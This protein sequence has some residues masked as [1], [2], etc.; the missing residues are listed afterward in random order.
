[1]TLETD[2][3][4]ESSHSI[5]DCYSSH[6]DEGGHHHSYVAII[7]PFFL[8]ATGAFLK[9]SFKSIPIPYTVLLLVLGGV[10]GLGLQKSD[11]WDNQF[12]TSMNFLADIP[13]HLLLHI[14]LPPLIFESAFSIEWYIFDKMKYTTA[15]L[16]GPGLVFSTGC[17]GLL[18][19]RVMIPF[20]SNTDFGVC[21]EGG[22][23]SGPG[24]SGWSPSA[25]FLLGAILSATDPV[26][27]VAL[28]KELGVPADLSTL[29]EGE[30][31]LNDGT[32]LVVYTVLVEFVEGT[33]EMT[34]VDVVWQFVKMSLGGLVF[35]VL[36][37]FLSVQWLGHIFNDAMVEITITLAVPYLTFYLAENLLHISGVL[38]L[39]ALG[40][41]YGMEGRSRISPEVQHFLG[42]FWELLAYFGNTL[43]FII[44]GLVI[45]KEFP[46]VDGHDIA[47][48]VIIYLFSHVIRAAVLGFVHLWCHLRGKRTNWN[49]D[50]VC[51]WGGLRGAVGLAL[52]LL[53]NTDNLICP[54]YK[55]VV[56]LQTAGLVLLTVIVNGSTMRPLLIRLGVDKVHSSRLLIFNQAVKALKES[57]EDQ[58]TLLK[59]DSLFDNADWDIVKSFYFQVPKLKVIEESLLEESLNQEYRWSVYNRGAT[60]GSTTNG[61]DQM[62]LA[63]R[64]SEESVKKRS[65]STSKRRTRS[66]SKRSKSL[67][68]ES[69]SI[70]HTNLFV[71]SH[72]VKEARRRLLM[73]CKKSYWRQFEMGLLSQEAA[74]FLMYTT[75]KAVDRGCVMAEWAYFE[76]TLTT[77]KHKAI[78]NGGH[79][80]SPALKFMDGIW[81]FFFIVALS[82][83]TAV[84]AFQ[85]GSNDLE[86]LITFVYPVHCWLTVVFTLEL[87]L[88]L[89]LL[90]DI[91][92]FLRDPFTMVDLGV[93]IIDIVLYYHPDSMGFAGYCLNLVRLL[94]GLRLLLVW[95]TAKQNKDKE[96]DDHGKLWTEDDHFFSKLK[97]KFIYHQVQFDYEVVCG[98]LSAREEA[99][100]VLSDVMDSDAPHFS[101]VREQALN[102]IRSAKHRLELMSQH[103]AEIS[104]SM[105]TYVAARTVLNQQRTMIDHLNHEGLLDT[106]EAIKMHGAVEHQMKK[107]MSKPPVVSLPNKDAI[108]RDL[109]WTS[110]LQQD[111]I[112]S[113]KPYFEDVV[114]E[115][116]EYVVKKG[117]TD[118]DVYVVARGNFTIY[119]GS[120]SRKREIGTLSMG[121]TFGEIS[122]ALGN[123]RNADV[124]SQGPGLV[125]KLNGETLH[126]LANLDPDLSDAIWDF[127]CRRLAEN[128]LYKES[129]VTMTR[130]MI[131]QTLMSFHPYY[132]S[133]ETVHTFVY[134]AILVLVNGGAEIIENV[135]APTSRLKLFAPDDEQ[136]EAHCHHEYV[137]GC[138]HC[139]IERHRE[140]QRQH[141][142]LFGPAI[143][144]VNTELT[145]FSVKFDKGAR[146]MAERTAFTFATTPKTRTTLFQ[147]KNSDNIGSHLIKKNVPVTDAR[148]NSLDN[149]KRKHSLR[150]TPMP[151]FPAASVT[152]PNTTR[153]KQSSYDE[154]QPEEG[155]EAKNNDQQHSNTLR[156]PKKDKTFKIKRNHSAS[157]MIPSSNKKTPNKNLNDQDNLL[158]NG[159]VINEPKRSNIVAPIAQ[160][161]LS[162]NVKVF[163]GL[164]NS[165]STQKLDES[166]YKKYRRNSSSLSER[167]LEIKVATSDANNSSLVHPNI[168]GNS[169]N[170]S[171]FSGSDYNI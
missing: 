160:H 151:K 119:D 33:F 25:G 150:N 156:L 139:E 19:N 27:V 45:G 17:I 22:F 11:E 15:F 42:E 32:A 142:K 118:N 62:L 73:V 134:D 74:K 77:F 99:L 52:A 30:S 59:Q 39:V 140:E 16:A 79:R 146:F 64:E 167:A 7:A 133:E 63:G 1:M 85:V 103:Y 168:R 127:V 96:R 126:S 165:S 125:Y 37:G 128:M 112:N 117:G 29:I 169:D 130:R 8:L 10:I 71:N 155:E 66:I 163:P 97:R 120:R 91:L 107:L 83:S 47:I 12:A 129:S 60:G 144:Q 124:I 164:N 28:L 49:Y 98:F 159:D 84:L 131:K 54:A 90:G 3:L 5:S 121:S 43:V 53:V 20:L 48:L 4:E 61:S 35:G 65:R 92:S 58:E 141:N 21:I 114:T 23:A 72:D 108:L 2:H 106:S 158:F 145:A 51:M 13:A 116:G 149:M 36:M 153:R 104:K 122:W 89:Y 94:R 100:Q 41:Y 154:E 55:D 57:E 68:Y 24:E 147:Y 67:R 102:D 113:L 31:L 26:A 110:N 109:E 82:L 152:A 78:M 76:Y 44:T 132:M 166:M 75:D 69:S 111:V 70:S 136:K 93:V 115:A 101:Y 86:K 105:A 137:E 123:P 9:N 14:F 162:K 148:K 40:L 87:S 95:H 34:A 143:I 81:Y 46:T 157:G 170:F 171:D 18:F 38:A 80:R 88:R 50:V 6:T 138:E 135:T 161:L 56:L